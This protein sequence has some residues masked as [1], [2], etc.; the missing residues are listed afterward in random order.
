LNLRHG[1]RDR[2]GADVDGLAQQRLGG[3]C[4]ARIGNVH[5]V[6]PGALLE[7][8]GRQMRERSGSR[9]RVVEAARL[10]LR[11]RDQLLQGVYAQVRPRGEHDWEIADLGHGLEVLERV[12]GHL[13]VEAR[14]DRKRIRRQQ[15]RVAVGS[16]ARDPREGDI[17]AGAAAVLDD[18]RLAQSVAERLLDDPRHDVVGAARRERD[19]EGHRPL[20]VERERRV[21]SKRG[22]QQS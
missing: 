5:H 6:D 19:D 10:L 18:D 9:R 3:R 7:K 12:V 8:L 16:C 20:G 2:H 17:A 22:S 1:D 4:R 15:Q 11:P 14:I 13:V 21:P